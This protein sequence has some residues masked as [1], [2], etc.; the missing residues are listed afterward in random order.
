MSIITFPVPERALRRCCH[1]SP[2]PLLEVA[3]SPVIPICLVTVTLEN[4][5]SLGASVLKGKERKSKEKKRKKKRKNNKQKQSNQTAT[6]GA[7]T[8]V[9]TVG[10]KFLPKEGVGL[11]LLEIRGHSLL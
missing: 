5:C 6:P 10:C 3:T 7:M 8:S 11:R 9:I 1:W 4:D 2:V